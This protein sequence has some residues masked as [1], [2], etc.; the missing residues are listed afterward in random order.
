MLMDKLEV[1]LGALQRRC[2]D[3]KIPVVILFEGLD[4][5]GKGVQISKLVHSMDPRWFQVYPMK[6]EAEAEAMRPF[7]WRYW[8]K[9]PKDGEIS[10]F[11]YSWYHAVTSEVFRK[12]EMEHDPKVLR[13]EINEF[14]RQIVDGGTCLIKLYLLIEHDEQYARMRAL[15]ESKSTS[16]RVTPEEMRRNEEYD[17]Y[18]RLVDEVLTETDTE[19]ARWNPIAATDRRYATVKIYQTIIRAIEKQIDEVLK[20][21]DQAEKKK[22]IDTTKIGESILATVD[23]TKKLEEEEYRKKLNK[24]QKKIQKLHG[25]LYR[26][27]I[28][29]IIGFEGWDAGGKGGAIRRLTQ[30]MDPRGY[31]VHPV[32]APTDIEKVHHYLW[33][34]WTKV[35]KNGHVAVFDRTWY[36]R[37]LVERIEGFCTRKEWKRAYR[38]INEMEASFVEEGAIV[39]KFWLHVDKDE[40]ERRFIE[41]QTT[42]EKQWKI[43]DED[44]RN[45]EKWDEYEVAVNEMIEK[46]STPHAPWVIVEGNNKYYARIKVLETVINAIEKRLESE[47]KK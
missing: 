21:A 28:P 42:P 19:F 31:A 12:K 4:V 10:I 44:W 24:L 29:V 27:R 38:E 13:Q 1:Q 39:L 35:P 40:Q 37:V 5:S 7:L 17:A 3:L 23:L 43:T 30:K 26:R 8:N 47:D 22:K 46:T 6:Q 16:W 18:T 11:D 36:G 15:G 41:R 14:E 32:A 34:F 45:R 20:K 2:I 25:Q 33:R 9:L